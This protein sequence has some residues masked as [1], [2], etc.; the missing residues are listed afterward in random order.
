MKRALPTFASHDDQ[1]EDSFNGFDD[2]DDDAI[3]M[4]HKRF[5]SNDTNSV[6]SRDFQLKKSNRKPTR[7]PDPSVTNRNALMARENRRKNKE[8]LTMLEEQNERIF[9][10]NT[11]L[12]NK[13]K[14]KDSII[15]D[16]RREMMHLKSIIANKTQI[17][18]ILHAIQSA[19]VPMTSSI[20]TKS[21]N[22][23]KKHLSS[24]KDECEMSP[25][26]ASSSGYESPT[27]TSSCGDTNYVN[28]TSSTTTNDIFQD[29]FDFQ[30]LNFT[31]Y[32]MDTNALA[33]DSWGCSSEENDGIFPDLS[34]EMF[35][36]DPVVAPTPPAVLKQGNYSEHNY[37]EPG[38]A[39]PGVCLH[40]SNQK[41]SIEFCGRCHDSAA[42]GKDFG[43]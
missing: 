37:S 27:L 12:A 17:S 42:S 2:T 5:K 7:Q 32:E 39:D 6:D 31:D 40:I 9:Q 25:S 35:E 43:I 36:D 28:G 19:G 26:T 22:I 13:L 21:D 30:T 1:S 4:L 15:K 38:D 23:F 33:I 24:T 8:R 14:V 3:S 34:P 16:L 10:Q 18:N 41:V 11:I 29:P 20:T